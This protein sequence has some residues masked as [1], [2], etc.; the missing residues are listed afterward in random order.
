MDEKPTAEPLDEIDVEAAIEEESDAGAAESE[1]SPPVVDGEAADDG[2]S[3]A[4]EELEGQL[5][6]APS[7]SPEEVLHV[8]DQ[9]A[10]AILDEGVSLEG[11]E[12]DLVE[13]AVDEESEEEH[14]PPEG[15]WSHA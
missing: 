4:S 15:A 6:P 14:R 11:F 12:E 8:E 2:V 3:F 9:L 5:E 10:E 7:S 1:E 13:V